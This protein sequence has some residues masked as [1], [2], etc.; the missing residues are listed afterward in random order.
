MLDLKK[1]KETREKAGLSQAAAAKKAGFKRVQQWNDVEAGRYPG[2]RL[3]TLEAIAK[4][5]GVK[6]RDLLK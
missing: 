6:A 4:A 5:L 3:T 2:I 1:L